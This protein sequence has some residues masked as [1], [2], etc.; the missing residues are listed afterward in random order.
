MDM[1]YKLKITICLLIG[2]ISIYSSSAQVEGDSVE[3]V[4]VS[5]DV[6][7]VKKVNSKE[8]NFSFENASL[9]ELLSQAGF[10]YESER[11]VTTRNGFVYGWYFKISDLWKIKIH[12]DKKLLKEKD[13]A[14]LNDIKLD[15]VKEEKIKKIE[16][17][18]N[19]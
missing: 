8:I 16:I 5:K 17:L 12:F 13:N 18:R 9:G 4:K 6:I 7:S 14:Y 2:L 3:Y 15:A 1:G 19:R 11:P 10:S